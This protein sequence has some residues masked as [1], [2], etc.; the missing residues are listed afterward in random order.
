MFDDSNVVWGGTVGCV[1][2][3]V[4]VL[5]ENGMAHSIPFFVIIFPTDIVV[6]CDQCPHFQKTPDVFL[7]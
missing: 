2:S 5:I 7:N 4:R 6:K 1:E 3:Q